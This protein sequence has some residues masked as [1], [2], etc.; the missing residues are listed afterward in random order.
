MAIFRVER[1]K[2]YTSMSNFHFRDKNLTWK[3]KGILSTML[4]LPEN[5]DY[6]LKGLV[7]LSDDGMD[8][9]RSAIKEL[10]AHGYLIRKPVRAENGRISDWEYVIFEYPPVAEKPVVEN[11]IVENPLVENRTQ[12]NTKEYN[13]IINTRSLVDTKE[14][15]TKELKH[16]FYSEGS[17]LSI[18]SKGIGEFKNVILTDEELEKL[19]EAYPSDYE[20][21]IDRLSVYIKQTG[22]H[23]DNHYAVLTA[24]AREDE[25]KAKCNAHTEMSSF[26][27]DSFFEAAMERGRS[28]PTATETL[29]WELEGG[30]VI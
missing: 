7:T 13:N 23:Y 27:T 15:I 28:K 10:E 18:T 4:S 17:N 26:E 6:S 11:P 24:W 5:W 22:K 20:A 3:A 21:K 2:N 16:S 19:K 9:T 29:P 30:N 14:L 25:A 8:A 12:L 1:S